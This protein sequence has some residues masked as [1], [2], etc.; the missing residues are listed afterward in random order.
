MADSITI[1]GTVENHDG[2][3]PQNAVIT[4]TLVTKNFFSATDLVP[5]GE[6]THAIDNDTGAVSITL[7]VPDDADQAV[8]YHVRLPDVSSFFV[9]VSANSPTDLETFIG[10]AVSTE[11]YDAAVLDAY[12]LRADI[13][14]LAELNTLIGDATLDD[15]GDAR[16]PTSHTH[17]YLPLDGAILSKSTAYELAAGDEGK[18]IECNGT[19]TV[20]LPDGLDTGFQAAIINVGSGTITL[21]AATTLQSKDAAVT[22]PNQYG[23]ATIYN[24]GSDVWLAF[25]DLA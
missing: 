8:R 22:L 4:T 3:I 25:G 9:G 19:F 24:R 18:I 17:E 10:T 5:T 14:T 20:T 15:S 23:A 16:T 2:T 12:L 1:T 7:A 21:A 6:E 11:T 13:D